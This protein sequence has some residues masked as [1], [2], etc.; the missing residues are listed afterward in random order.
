MFKQL[1]IGIDVTKSFCQI[2]IFDS[3]HNQYGDPFEIPNTIK[4]LNSLL[5]TIEDLETQFNTNAVFVMES[6]NRTISNFL[7]NNGYHVYII[8]HFRITSFNTMSD[9]TDAQILAEL[10][11]INP[12]IYNRYHE[13]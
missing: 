12:H 6:A 10:Y 5:I 4:G 13:T 8:N 2:A 7:H 11:F 1:I 3:F 9:K